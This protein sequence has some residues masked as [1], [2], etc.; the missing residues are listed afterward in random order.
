M[1]I[2]IKYYFLNISLIKMTKKARLK[3]NNKKI[4]YNYL[5]KYNLFNK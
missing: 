5:I 3:L 1:P 2:L 4:K